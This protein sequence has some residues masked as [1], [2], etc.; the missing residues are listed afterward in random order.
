[1]QLIAAYTWRVRRLHAQAPPV[2]CRTS[3]GPGRV[4]VPGPRRTG[5]WM[6]IARDVDQDVRG[7]HRRSRRM[8]VPPDSVN[9][10]LPQNSRGHWPR[11]TLDQTTAKGPDRHLFQD[12]TWD[13]E[14]FGLTRSTE[15]KCTERAGE[16]QRGVSTSVDLV[17]DGRRLRAA[18]DQL[19]GELR[20]K[21]QPPAGRIRRHQRQGQRRV[22]IRAHG[23]RP[24]DLLPE[25][26]ARR[27]QSADH[28]DPAEHHAAA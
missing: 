27:T 15:R 18:A 7:S 3:A 21:S 1:M 13:N 4:R 9:L 24:S 26:H 8:R 6:A 14:R 22:R 2:A 25:A 20:G 17:V 5:D 10:P 23:E 19:R 12:A 16:A 11:L 28:P